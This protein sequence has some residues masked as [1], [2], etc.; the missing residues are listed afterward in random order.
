MHPLNHHCVLLTATYICAAAQ[1]THLCIVQNKRKD[2]VLQETS[3]CKCQIK[4]SICFTTSCSFI[5]PWAANRRHQASGDR[6]LFAV[7]T[8]RPLKC[9]HHKH[10]PSHK[11]S[12]VWL[13]GCCQRE[14]TVA[15]CDFWW[16]QE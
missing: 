16:M 14:L 7:A 1:E 9:I 15:S 13:S 3:I 8:R 12:Q 10:S 4:R 11:L 5:P 6:E 2:L